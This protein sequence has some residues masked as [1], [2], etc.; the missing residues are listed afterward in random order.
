[1]D[2]KKGVHWCFLSKYK[3]KIYFYDSFDRNYKNLNSK[4][5]N[6]KRINANTNIDQSYEE[7]NSGS[8]CMSWLISF[9]K[10]KDKIINII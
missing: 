4:W 1:M 7:S 2:N 9:D 10:Y 5:K 3:N 6:N 8:R